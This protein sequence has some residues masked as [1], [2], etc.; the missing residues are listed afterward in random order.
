[1]K[2]CIGNYN[3]GSSGIMRIWQQIVAFAAVAAALFM[4][5]TARGAE[6]T[7]RSS[8]LEEVIVTAEF[9]E[10][11]LQDTPIAITA[12]SGDVLDER[13]MSSVADIG[14]V[15]PNV[16]ISNTGVTQGPAAAI[17]I[18]GVGQYDSN[19]GYEPGVGVYV[20]DVYLGALNGN[21]LDLL[22]LDRVEVL[23]GPQGTLAGRNSIGGAIKLYSR[24]PKGDNSG[25]AEATIGDANKLAVRAALDV[26]LIA[27]QLF[28][29]V[30]GMS[31]RQ[32][33]YVRLLD[34]RCTHP[35]ATDVPQY[36]VRKDC[37]T[38]TLGGK[39]VA[40]FRGSLRWLASEALD[41]TL[42][43][44]YIKDRSEVTATTLLLQTQPP[45]A[46]PDL[47]FASPSPYVAYYNFTDANTGEHYPNIGAVDA[48]GLGL[49]LDWRLT[50]SLALKSI[51]GYRRQ[52]AQY[53]NDQ[54]ADTNVPG[55]NYSDEI[56][57]QASE[58]LR[59]SGSAFNQAVDWTLGAYYFKSNSHLLSRVDAAPVV[60]VFNDHH[61]DSESSSGF[62]HVVWHAID[63]LNVTV[64]VRYTKDDKDF[65]FGQT[66]ATAVAALNG[67]QRTYSGSRTDYRVGVD[68]RWSDALMTYAQVSTGYKGGGIN[69]RPLDST[70][71]ITFKPEFLDAY[72]IGLKSDLLDRTLR[73]NL[74][75]FYNKYKDIILVN[76]GPCCGPT[77]NPFFSITAFNAGDANIK[78]VEAE[79]EW[80]P[81]KALS[82]SASG[83]WLKFDYTRIATQTSDGSPLS[84]SIPMSG[85]TPY[86]AERAASLGVSYAFDLPSGSMLT[87]RVDASYQGPRYTDP[88][89]AATSYLDSYTVLNARLNWQSAN[90]NWQ[91]TAAVDNVTD[92]V[93]YTGS[94]D[95]VQFSGTV[96]KAIA[97]PRAAYVTVRRTF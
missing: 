84:I 6:S 19:L 56:F 87:P 23:R 46:F 35:T 77:G 59:L 47:R 5:F 2:A 49:T 20:D 96:Q 95:A 8:A 65:L 83:S 21:F 78:G 28:L 70:Q 15:A 88:S 74:A 51:S 48:R 61:I 12:L 43:A 91:V 90:A 44:D 71:V 58:E 80:S 1:M 10:A 92:K 50:D 14:K 45:F 57:E 69:P 42:N 17:Y 97:R 79:L 81:V 7:S 93:Y 66:G 72:E 3:Q 41:F 25:F 22:D 89:N 82:I 40:G 86:T 11:K 37:R 62:G 32:D 67:L 94:F 31:N 4:P 24:R 52:E 16:N 76:S 63:R 29:R 68:Y 75:A 30:S 64:G 34:Y 13:G 55:L 27:N 39:N 36:S 33:G 73:L 54:K 26:P 38:G 9:R 85:I 60:N 18:R 53:T